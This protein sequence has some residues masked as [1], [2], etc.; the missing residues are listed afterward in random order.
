MFPSN[1]YLAALSSLVVF[2]VLFVF[3][4]PPSFSL[5]SFG[6]VPII[7]EIHDFKSSKQNIWADLSD[8]EFNDVLKF[9]YSRP[10]GLNLT[11]GVAATP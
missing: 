5:L 9:L 8:L 6:R 3:L 10:N 1:K 11:K 4:T 7:H 2:T